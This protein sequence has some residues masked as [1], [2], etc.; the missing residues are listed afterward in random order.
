MTTNGQGNAHE[1]SL[2]V[3]KELINRFQNEKSNILRSDISAGTVFCTAESFERSI[4]DRIMV[5]T[6]CVGLRIYY[7]MKEDLSI[8]AILVGYNSSGADIL[9][10]S[11]INE[12]ECVEDGDGVIGEDATR[13]PPVCPPPG[14]SLIS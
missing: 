7:G 10:S 11:I 1:I 8:H 2:A 9:P 14:C 3:A 6:D 12:N 5:Q 4:V 13:C